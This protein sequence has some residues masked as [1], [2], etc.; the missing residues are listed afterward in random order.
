MKLTYTICAATFIASFG[1]SG[2]ARAAPIYLDCKVT[3]QTGITEAIGFWFDGTNKP[4]VIKI[5]GADYTVTR[6]SVSAEY[7]IA[8]MTGFNGV[9]IEVQVS[10]MTKGAYLSFRNGGEETEDSPYTGTCN[11]SDQPPK[12]AF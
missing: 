12:P 7:V 9:E 10:R 11:V 8:Y 2:M 5:Q 4:T 1:W 6:G 3:G